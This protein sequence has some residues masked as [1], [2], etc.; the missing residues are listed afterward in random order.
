MQNDF[1]YKKIFEL[2]KMSLEQLM[3]Y[4]RSLRSFEYDNDK[5]MESS[6]IKKKIFFLTKIILKADA[7]ISQR[8]LIIFNDKRSSGSDKG[9]VYAA[10]HV[11]RYDIE[12]SMEAINEPAFFVMGDPEETYRNFEGFFLDKIYG[13]I[14]FDTGYCISEIFRKHQNGIELSELERE[15]FDAYKKDRHICEEVCTKRVADGDNI[16]LY[17]EGAWNVTARITQTL[18]PGAA[19]IAVKGNGLLVPIGVLRDGKKYS[20][21]IGEEIDVSGATVSDV[22]DITAELKERMNSLV[23][24]MIFAGDR[25][26]QR[27]EMGTSRENE[28]IFINDMMAETSNGYTLDVI[29]KT[30]YYNPN[31]P[32]NVIGIIG[33]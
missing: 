16:L 23:G 20:V 8:K 12:S 26:F 13:R 6:K 17:P 29:E 9:K 28:E 10:S 21:N 24:E 2:K 31:D 3:F 7:I 15:V 18:Y 19:R 5:P 30:R 4:Y 32:E 33:I 27:S 1:E 11:G 25:I 14:C 22:K